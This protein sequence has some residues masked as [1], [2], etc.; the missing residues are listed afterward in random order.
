MGAWSETDK[1][2]V[3][4]VGRVTGNAATILWHSGHSSTD[5]PPVCLYMDTNRGWN[6]HGTCYDEKAYICEFL[7]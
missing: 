4:F 2:I 6:Q 1:S 7:P 3:T 5:T